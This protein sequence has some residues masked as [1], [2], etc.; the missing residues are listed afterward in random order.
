[1][2]VFAATGLSGVEWSTCLA[3]GLQDANHTNKIAM[4]QWVKYLLFF[5][6]ALCLS[7]ESGE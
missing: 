5:M 6:I 7:S 2:V 4:L 1:M 3:A